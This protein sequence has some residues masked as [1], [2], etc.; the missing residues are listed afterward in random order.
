MQLQVGMSA[1][2]G[3]PAKVVTPAIVPATAEIV[4]SFS[5]IHENYQNGEFHLKKKTKSTQLSISH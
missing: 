1:T 3:L 5:E 2:A 4:V